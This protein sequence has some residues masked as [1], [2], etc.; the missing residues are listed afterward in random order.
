MKNK[1][2]FTSRFPSVDKEYSLPLAGRARGGE[3]NKSIFNYKALSCR[4]P[5]PDPSNEGRGSLLYSI[6][7]ALNVRIT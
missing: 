7:F 2:E 6:T 4:I 5:S 3:C 1:P